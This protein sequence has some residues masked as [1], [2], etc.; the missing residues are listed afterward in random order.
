MKRLIAGIIGM[1]PVVAIAWNSARQID[2]MSKESFICVLLVAGIFIW[3]WLIM[4]A[5]TGVNGFSRTSR[6]GNFNHLAKRCACGDKVA[7]GYEMCTNCAVKETL[8]RR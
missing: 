7:P 6:A 4:Y 5:L 8:A 2:F 3:F 1:A